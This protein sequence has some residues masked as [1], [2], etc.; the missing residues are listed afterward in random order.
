MSV[1]D[2]QAG[3][4]SDEAQNEAQKTESR[5]RRALGLQGRTRAAPAPQ[6]RPEDARQRHRFVQD[7]EVPVV[8][9]HRNRDDAPGSPVNRVAA[10]EATLEAERA[11]HAATARALDEAQ[12]A[13]Q[14]L[15]TK[16]AHA[17]MGFREALGAEQQ[18]R[19]RAEA[20]LHD[21]LTPPPPPEPDTTAEADPWTAVEPVRRR[22][23][24]PKSTA[25]TAVGTGTPAPTGDAEPEPEPEPV[26]WWLPGFGVKA[27]AA[28]PGRRKPGRPKTR[29]I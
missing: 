2:D 18:A 22:P 11:A 21:A 3:P 1:F 4:A 6:Q 26:K 15:R 19:E 14:S 27:G 23:G 24:R 10:V 9:L 7:G 13:V 29:G 5:M 28:S 12:A 8:V 17:E 20:A 16:L 25:P